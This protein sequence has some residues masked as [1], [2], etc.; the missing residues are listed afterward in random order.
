MY[1]P[2]E[3]H[4]SC[5]PVIHGDFVAVLVEYYDFDERG[6][7]ENNYTGILLMNWSSSEFVIIPGE[8][9]SQEMSLISG[10]LICLAEEPRFHVPAFLEVYS[11]ASFD[12]FWQPLTNLS[13][14]FAALE[15]N[16]L[17][18][19]PV[20]RSAIDYPPYHQDN[21]SQIVMS[22]HEC[23]LNERASIVS[24]YISSRPHST[25]ATAS[26]LLLLLLRPTLH[27]PGTACY[28]LG[29]SIYGLHRTWFLYRAH[30]LSNFS[31]NETAINDETALAVP[32][33]FGEELGQ[34][35]VSAYSGATIVCTE[36]DVEISYFL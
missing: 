26:L 2:R 18:V 35:S 33:S 16:R 4:G 3:F 22:V 11:V 24:L 32:L 7:R 10:Y 21:F 12:S 5:P 25:S 6:D 20:I 1:L 29:P 14:S 19:S 17:T 27:L 13:L 15:I 31:N 8:F 9:S 36:Y 30:A 23:L 34:C 28:G